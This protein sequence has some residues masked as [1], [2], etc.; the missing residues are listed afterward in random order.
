MYNVNVATSHLY[1]IQF[2][3]ST[4][5]QAVIITVDILAHLANQ[6]CLLF[7]AEIV[8]HAFTVEL[9]NMSNRDL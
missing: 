4:C 9:V 7:Q 8:T 6:I 5:I 1:T 2:T 3:S